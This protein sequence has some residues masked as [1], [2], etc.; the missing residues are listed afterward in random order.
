LRAADALRNHH[1]KSGKILILAPQPVV[2]PVDRCL[3]A[4]NASASFDR[5]LERWARVLGVRN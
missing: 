5:P 3:A 4:V 1:H 2:D